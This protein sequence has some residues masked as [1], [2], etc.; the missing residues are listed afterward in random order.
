MRKF[1]PIVGEGGKRYRAVGDMKPP[2]R[3]FAG[4]PLRPEPYATVCVSNAVE[5]GSAQS[6]AASPDFSN[7][8]VHRGHE[9]AKLIVLPTA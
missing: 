7:C 6:N 1:S 4:N 8:E 2:V 5:R 9:S 3:N